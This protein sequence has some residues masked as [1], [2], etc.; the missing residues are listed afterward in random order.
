MTEQ[1]GR[2][3]HLDK[4]ISISHFISTF[5]IFVSFAIWASNL[6]K[7]VETNSLNLSH[8]GTAFEQHKVDQDHREAR[9]DARYS[10]LR[11]EIREDL[12]AIREDL[13]KILRGLK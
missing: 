11:V 12:K 6:D 13:Q 8:L 7:R 9:Q 3:W 2:A 1:R 5:M 10:E 4:T